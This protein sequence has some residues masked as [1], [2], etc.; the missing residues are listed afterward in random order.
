MPKWSFDAP[1]EAI[2]V[3]LTKRVRQ[4]PLGMLGPVSSA[5]AGPG[6]PVR[7]RVAKDVI[8]VDVQPLEEYRAG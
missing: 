6:T 8:V 5:C 3:G 2:R 7:P 1:P 4:K